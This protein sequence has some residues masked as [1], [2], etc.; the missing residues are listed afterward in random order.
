MMIPLLSLQ[1]ASDDDREV[2]QHWLVYRRDIHG[3]KYRSWEKIP[4]DHV[5]K[6]VTDSPTG[7]Q[8]KEY[9]PVRSRPTGRQ[10]DLSGL[11]QLSATSRT[12]QSQAAGSMSRE[13]RPTFVQIP[14]SEKEG[15]VDS[16]PTIVDWARKCPVLWADKVNSDSM[17][18]V[19]WMLGYLSEVLASRNGSL[20]ELKPGDLEA[21]LQHVLCVLQ[22]CASHSEKSDFDHQAWKIARLYA[23]KVQAQ[24]DQGLST[25]SDFSSYRSNPHPSEL[26]SAKQEMEPRLIPKKIEKKKAEEDKTDRSKLPCLTWNT[27]SIENKCDWMVKNPDRGRCNRKHQCSYCTEKGMGVTHHQRTFCSRRIAAGEA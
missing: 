5:L 18:I 25:W 27:S 8:Y 1:R 12:R 19:I 20:P 15:K 13:R 21:K 22:V 3:Q 4:A 11:G 16:K 23:R 7:R 14:T 9:V 6:W 24:L 10:Q 17:N 26:I 2:Q